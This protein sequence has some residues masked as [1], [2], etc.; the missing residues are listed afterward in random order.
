[1]PKPPYQFNGGAAMTDARK[2]LPTAADLA[3]FLRQELFRIV[4]SP[5]RAEAHMR[6]DRLLVN[7]SEVVDDLYREHSPPRDH[8]YL[9]RLIRCQLARV[10]ALAEKPLHDEIKELRAAIAKAIDKAGDA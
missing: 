10:Q 8:D 9:M 3:L 6:D 2:P 4:A 7:I 1:V 5:R